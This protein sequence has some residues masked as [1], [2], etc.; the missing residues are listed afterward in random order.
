VKTQYRRVFQS[1]RHLQL[2]IVKEYPGVPAVIEL[3]FLHECFGRSRTSWT[4]F[5]PQ[6]DLRAPLICNDCGKR[7]DL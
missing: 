2:A 3:K 4:V 5:S 6:T 1:A 7:I